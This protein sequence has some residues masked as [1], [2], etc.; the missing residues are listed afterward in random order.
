MHN[1]SAE[2]ETVPY[3]LACTGKYEIEWFERLAKTSHKWPDSPTFQLTVA[4]FTGR[5]QP[6]S[7]KSVED[8]IDFL[9]LKV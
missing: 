4:E 7:M 2:F 6:I 3:L 1:V 9:P 8:V 5:R